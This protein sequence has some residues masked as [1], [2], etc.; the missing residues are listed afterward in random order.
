M[1]ILYFTSTGNCLYVAK[2]IGGEL[3]SIPQLQKDGV[4]EIND[5][6][7][8]IVIP[9]YG[10]DVPRPVR[11][12]LNK[13]KIKSEYI[14]VIMTY[15]NKS[16]AALTQTRK[17]LE[18]NNIRLDYSNEI[19]MVDNYLPGFDISQQ[20]KMGKEADIELKIKDIINDISL[21]K[22]SLVKHNWL[23]RIISNIFSSVFKSESGKKMMNNFAKNFI[24]N[25]SCNG[26][27][28]CRKVCPMKNIS[29]ERKPE[30]QDKCEFCLACIH[31]CPKNAIHLKS[32]KS[33]KRFINQNIKPS[34]I[35]KANNQT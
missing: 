9:I 33:G 21:K 30:Y 1:K 24:V 11:L 16:M 35:I 13:V 4:Y 17:L 26:C 19:K 22:S 20:L 10:F 27:G 32:E 34:E 28:I 2:R 8:G 3:L 18:E 5:D 15:G 6:V 7:I 14:F 12:Y 31:L 25:D 23:K 29:G